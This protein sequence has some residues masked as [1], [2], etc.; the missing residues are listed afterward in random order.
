[1]SAAGG[2]GDPVGLEDML[3]RRRAKS[4][5]L[6]RRSMLFVPANVPRYIEKAH[7]RGAD[8]IIIDL[9]DS[10]PPSEKAAA[11]ITGR[12]A[13]PVVAR[14]GADVLVRINKPFEQA[15]KDLDA[16]VA[17]GLNGVLL[18]KTESA[19]EVTILN[20][21]LF[22]REIA[23][24]LEPGSIGVLLC[25]ETALGVF[26]TPAIIEECRRVERVFGV[27]YGA[28]DTTE[29][30]GIELTPEGWERFWGNGQTV[31]AAAAAGVQPYGRL[32]VAFDF[33]NIALY[34]DSIR[35]GALFGFK[36]SACIH[37]AQVDV[38]N[39]IFAPTAEQV[40]RAR[41][42][43]AVMDEAVKAGR[44]SANVDGRMVDIPTVKRAERNLE[45]AKAIE[46]KEARNKTPVAL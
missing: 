35:R 12:E 39:R 26:D 3:E 42:T 1:M 37:P 13:I 46:E 20:S 25:I 10:V 14:G 8:A 11:R 45:L 24:G 17:P 5:R 32:G 41:K 23:A 29:E 44:G 18:S 38:L 36:G 34:E 30:L 6:V 7:L 19:R 27:S 2:W 43:V 28:E 40:E 33:T 22:E 9:E 21:L 4:R 15:T 31:L 16:M